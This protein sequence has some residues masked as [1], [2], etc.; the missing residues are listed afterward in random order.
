[1]TEVALSVVIPSLNSR[2]IDQVITALL[3]QVQCHGRCDVTVV[4][5][6]EGGLVRGSSLVRFIDTGNP[7]SA[8]AA[9]NIGARETSGEIIC[10]LDSD[11]IPQDGWLDS[12]Y[13]RVDRTECIAGGAMRLG[14]TD[15]WMLCGNVSSF[16]DY[17]AELAAGQRSYLPSFSLAIQRRLFERIG[18]FDERFGEAAEDLDFSVRARNMGIALEFEPAAVVWHLPSRSSLRSFLRHSVI[19]GRNSI[20][21]RRYYPNLFGMP[22]IL[23]FPLALLVLSP[24]VA[25]HSVCG[26]YRRNPSIR[27]NWSLSVF[28][29]LAKISWCLGAFTTLRRTS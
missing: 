16:H 11:C 8:A 17:S 5:K 3:P 26:I 27:A 23:T 28:L 14:G 15:F 21:V 7:V 1:M 9:R 4:G 24:L 25:I 12:M 6:D 19:S 22:R 10:F 13:H 18:G 29:I 20:R 2:V